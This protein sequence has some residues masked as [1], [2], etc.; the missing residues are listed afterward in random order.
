[1]RVRM[2]ACLALSPLDLFRR[3]QMGASYLTVHIHRVVYNS[4]LHIFC[5]NQTFEV[6]SA[7]SSPCL[8]FPTEPLMQ[9]LPPQQ[10]SLEEFF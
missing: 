3:L 7:E 5:F 6:F 10:R 4:K 8:L 9:R 2:R 1:M